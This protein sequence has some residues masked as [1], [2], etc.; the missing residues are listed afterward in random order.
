LLAIF[1]LCIYCA[2]T[3]S[4]WRFTTM[5]TKAKKSAKKKGGKKKAAKKK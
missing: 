4:T 2:R 5:A 1:N 3:N